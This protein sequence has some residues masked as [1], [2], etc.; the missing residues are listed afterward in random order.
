MFAD[1]V[2]DSPCQ[3]RSHRG[4]T[5]LLSFTLQA[6]AVATLF[7]LPIMHT[8]GVPSLLSPPRLRVP[9]ALPRVAQRQ[10]QVP[11]RSRW[12]SIVPGHALFTPRHIPNG[13]S[14]PAASDVQPPSL[15]TA[16]SG[17]SGLPSSSDGIFGSTGEL[18]PVI[19]PHPLAP[20]HH[21]PVSRMMEGNLIHRVEPSY[22]TLAK[23]AR[24][25][26]SVLLRATIGKDGSIENLHLLSGHPM[27]AQAAVEAVRQ[28]R[29]RPYF[30]N[31]EPVEVETQVTV[32]FVL[33][34]G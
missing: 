26:G 6:M 13:I 2:C 8:L 5:T 27:L 25:Q 31:G 18:F 23:Q 4:W 17:S 24:I 30:L 32:N 15:N 16:T 7:A 12:V 22:P 20:A 28:W 10:A 14:P 19:I 1:C 11:T 3:N 33:S 21:P 9:L 29:Y 34:G